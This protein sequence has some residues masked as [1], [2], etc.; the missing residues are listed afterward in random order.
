MTIYAI[1]DLHLSFSNPKPMDIFGSEW[2]DHHEKIAANWDK[3][4]KDDDVVIVAGDISWALKFDQAQQDLEFINQR[5]GTKILLRGN[6]DYWWRRES[7]GKIQTQLP[8][9]MLLM[10]AK[11]Y[12][13]ENVGIAGT[14]GWR[15]ELEDKKIG[16]K[17][18]L[19]REIDYFKKALGSIPDIVE[20]K[21]AVLHYPPYETDMTL[22]AFAVILK[23]YNIDTL[24]YGHIHTNQYLE[25]KI[26]GVMYKLVSVDHTGFRP[27]KV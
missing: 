2:K 13:F 6:H 24:I 18:V 19:S 25:G 9:N 1:S 22:N 23:E 26:D 15:Q 4:V 16:S 7:T 10:H 14:R 20:R 12:V 27:V 11:A 17:K 5:P 8:K 3:L 21:I